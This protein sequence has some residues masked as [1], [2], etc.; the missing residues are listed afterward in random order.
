MAESGMDYSALNR[1]DRDAIKAVNRIL[2]NLSLYLSTLA[3]NRRPA[4]KKRRGVDPVR[5]EEG[6]DLYEVPLIDPEQG[7]V[8]KLDPI[9]RE[10]AAS[11]CREGKDPKRW[12][13]SS[14]IAVIGHWKWVPYGPMKPPE[15]VTDWKR[16]VRR[17][18]IAPY[19]RGPEASETVAKTYRAE[20]PKEKP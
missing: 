8:I 12:S 5:N 3:Q 16:P 7:T 6:Y 11:W 9:L 13:L 20:G 18:W 1:A 2:M 4:Q 10:A 17:K 14:R 15:G 19:K